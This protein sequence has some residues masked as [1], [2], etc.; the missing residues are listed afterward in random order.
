MMWRKLVCVVLLGLA[1]HAWAGSQD[2]RVSHVWVR[3]SLPG[4]T[5]ASVE[6]V[7]TC[8]TA[9]G[10]LVAVDSPAAES[11]EMQRP[12]PSG[13]KIQ[14]SKVRNVRL[15]RGR[16]VEFGSRGVSLML[17]GLKQPLKAGE[18]I[19]VNLTVL[20]MDGQKITVEARAEVKP[21]ELSKQS[22]QSGVP[23]S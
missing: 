3:E 4:Q 20:L 19:P 10:R 15:P 22:P 1:S 6:A 14:M 16:P 17:L 5:T 18:H 13:G 12:W 9:S 23:A 2:V 11:A 8:V 21:S 7:V